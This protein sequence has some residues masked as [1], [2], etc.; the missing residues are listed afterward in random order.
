M[1][2]GKEFRGAL[3]TDSEEASEGFVE[4]AVLGE[5]DVEEEDLVG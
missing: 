2:C 4:K 1:V 3:R 5:I